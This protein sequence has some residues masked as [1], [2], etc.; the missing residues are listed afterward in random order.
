[1]EPGLNEVEGN[2]KIVKKRI[3]HYEAKQIYFLCFQ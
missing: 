3:C 2:E 1:M